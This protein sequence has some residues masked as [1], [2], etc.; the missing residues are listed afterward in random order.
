MYTDKNEPARRNRMQCY[1]QP[2]LTVVFRASTVMDMA[3]IAATTAVA[4]FITA[5]ILSSASAVTTVGVWRARCAWLYHVHK[6]KNR[7][8][9]F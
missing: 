5:G 7:P 8:Q 3:A 1:L 6:A 2:P 4:I 9:A